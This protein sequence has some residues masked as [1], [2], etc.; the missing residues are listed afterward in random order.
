MTDTLEDVKQ[1]LAQFKPEEIRYLKLSIRT[2]RFDAESKLY[3][4]NVR[5]FEVGNR[6]PNEALDIL[7]GEK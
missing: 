6:P 4:H 3:Q 1:Y 5:K 7:G 2:T